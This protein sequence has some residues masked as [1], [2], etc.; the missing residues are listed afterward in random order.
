[1]YADF[2]ALVIE[3]VHLQPSIQLPLAIVEPPLAVAKL[4]FNHPQSG[5]I[6]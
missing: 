2:V 3:V 6:Y 5:K 1:M 4:S